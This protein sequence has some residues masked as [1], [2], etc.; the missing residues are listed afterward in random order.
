M[1]HYSIVFF[2][3]MANI[4]SMSS[5]RDV[6]LLLGKFFFDAKFTFNCI[7][8]MY[9]EWCEAQFRLCVNFCVLSPAM[10]SSASPLF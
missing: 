1:F 7:V 9:R 2:I 10:R 8:R 4:K 3:K 6:T 5:C